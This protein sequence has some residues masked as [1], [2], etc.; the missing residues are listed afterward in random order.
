MLSTKEDIKKVDHHFVD[1]KDKTE[2]EYLHSKYPW[3]SEKVIRSAIEKQGPER[4]NIEDYL[5]RY[6][7]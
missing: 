7:S 2:V 1:P 3:I 5:D 6:H 4:K